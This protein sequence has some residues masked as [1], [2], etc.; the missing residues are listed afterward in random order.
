M[1]H[2]LAV[3]EVCTLNHTRVA[4]YDYLQVEV[5]EVLKK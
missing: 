2:N 4:L 1:C 5:T 3:D